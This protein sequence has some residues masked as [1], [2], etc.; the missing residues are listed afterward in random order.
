MQVISRPRLAC[1]NYVTER[2]KVQKR[3][4]GPLVEV[5]GLY[6]KKAMDVKEEE[7][8]DQPRNEAAELAR[9][10]AS[11]KVNGVLLVL[12]PTVWISVRPHQ[13]D[14]LYCSA[15]L[16]VRRSRQ[17]PSLLR[18]GSRK[19]RRNSCSRCHAIYMHQASCRSVVY[20]CIA[21]MFLTG[22]KYALW[23]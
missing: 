20:K 12:S 21:Q 5:L 7:D 6:W 22:V 11:S 2:K 13:L 4:E 8:V 15:S 16:E 17:R 19:P 14:C 1:Q 3:I 9:P 23:I 18:P 10:S